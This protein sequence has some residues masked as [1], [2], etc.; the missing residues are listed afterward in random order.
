MPLDDVQLSGREVR[1]FP[2]QHI[3]SDR[4]AELRA[5]ASFLA[6]TCAVSEFGRAVVSLAGG[7]KGRT[8]SYTEVPFI[9]QTGPKSCED[10]PDG[11]LRSTFGKRDWMALVEVKVGNNSLEQ[12]QF[13]RYHTLAN[14]HQI[15]ALITISSFHCNS[16]NHFRLFWS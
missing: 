4:E 12:E 9:T 7:P 11:I 2:S 16:F 14:D 1:L 13:E 5:T 3:K 8:R 6:V 15:D 10:R